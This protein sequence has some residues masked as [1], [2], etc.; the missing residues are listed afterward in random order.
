MDRTF[1]KW[2]SALKPLI[3]ALKQMGFDINKKTRDSP[4]INGCMTNRY[5]GILATNEASSMSKWAKKIGTPMDRG[6]NVGVSTY[7]TRWMTVTSKTWRS[8]DSSPVFPG[9]KVLMRR[10]YMEERLARSM[11]D[12]LRVDFKVDLYFIVLRY[13]DVIFVSNI[14]RTLSCDD[15]G[16]NR[17]YTT[18]RFVKDADS[19]AE[20]SPVYF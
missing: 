16:Y 19:S 2:I 5:M 18:T 15:W 10:K 7:E 1:K 3:L 13:F 8:T 6:K 20:I 9:S 17:N 4:S 14:W 11:E 12:E